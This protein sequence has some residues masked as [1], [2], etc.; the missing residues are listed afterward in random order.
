[1]IVVKL[2]GGLGNQ[3]FQYAT[4]FALAQHHRTSVAVDL[5]FLLATPAQGTITVRDYELGVFGLAPTPAPLLDRIAYGIK[6]PPI[7]KKRLQKLARLALS[8]TEYREKSFRFDPNI[9]KKTTSRTYL[10][11]YFQSESYFEDIRSRLLAKAI[12]CSATFEALAASLSKAPY[13]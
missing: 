1:M 5:S 4:A 7:Q 6:R 12:V 3:L 11:G 10:V 13:R 8:G 2:Q 9:E